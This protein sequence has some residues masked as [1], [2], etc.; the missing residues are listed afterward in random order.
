MDIYDYQ[1]KQIFKGAGIPVLAGFVA[2]TPAEAEKKA[3]EIGGDKWFVKAQMSGVYENL[4][5]KEDA[6]KWVEKANA[7]SDVFEI[8]DRMLKEVFET[9][10]GPQKVKKV[11]VEKACDIAQKIRLSIQVD[12]DLQAVV[13]AIKNESD[14][15]L[16]FP[17]GEKGLTQ[18]FLK[19]C[20]E[21]AKVDKSDIM[22]VSEIVKKLY[23]VFREYDAVAVE[24]SPLII[25]KRGKLMALE[26][27]MIFDPDALF[28]VPE[29][30]KI[31][32]LS[33]GYERELT[34]FRNNFKYTRL[35][36]NI[37]CLVNG[38]GL[39]L[40]TVDL[41]HAFEG[42]V[43][44]LLDMGTEPTRETVSRAFKLILS[45][46]NIEGVLV[47]IFGG[48]TRCDVIAQGLIA[49]SK[50][51]FVGMPIVVRMDG[52]NAKI[53]ERILVESGLPFVIEHT[54]REAIE[55]IVKSVEELA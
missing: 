26:G 7:L 9:A 23:Q 46:P 41:I 48:T 55:K 45:E 14:R 36:G 37:A 12:F 50:E 51:I 42:D 16:R 47:N 53:G 10:I 1:V 4:R 28:K 18:S 19:E 29:I 44:C 17:V 8:A 35:S 2:Y 54:M 31:K 21:K 52:T 40:A 30:V 34:A 6:H 33:S 5:N 11:Y 49:A 22:S 43:A 15:I 27:R 39:G 25:T 38:T 20:L 32:E 3:S 13:F 24:I